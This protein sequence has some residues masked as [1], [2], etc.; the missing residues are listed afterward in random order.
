MLSSSLIMAFQLLTL[1][2]SSRRGPYA[3]IGGAGQ[4][5]D[6]FVQD[7]SSWQYKDPTRRG[8][9]LQD[10]VHSST[11]DTNRPNTHVRCLFRT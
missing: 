1:F 8:V 6:A 2:G 10:L 5:A 7:L 4:C 9:G 3:V 11:T